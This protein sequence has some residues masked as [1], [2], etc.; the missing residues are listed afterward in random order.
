MPYHGFGEVGPGRVRN[1]QWSQQS[2]LFGRACTWS[3]SLTGSLPS[4][5]VAS[6]Q[7][8]RHKLYTILPRRCIIAPRS[9]VIARVS[10]P[11]HYLECS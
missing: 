11:S 2:A 9:W 5:Q 4:L 8:L 3:E 1:F 7:V 10:V 6:I